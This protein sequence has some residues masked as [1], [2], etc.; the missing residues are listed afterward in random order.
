MQP[1]E[2]R[3]R[4]HLRR[5]IATFSSGRINHSAQVDNKFFG[6][7]QKLGCSG[8]QCVTVSWGNLLSFV[9]AHHLPNGVDATAASR[10]VPKMSIDLRHCRPVGHGKRSPYLK[11]AEHV[12]GAYNHCRHS[13]PAS[14]MKPC[15]VAFADNRH[16]SAMS[17]R[18]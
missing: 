10:L 3:I 8:L 9:I 13:L 7:R 5:A 2:R 4:P 6:E 11:I 18:C 12:A 1:I 14:A 17:V 16:V 15:S